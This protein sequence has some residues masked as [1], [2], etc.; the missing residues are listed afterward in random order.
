[1]TPASRA[2]SPP[3]RLLRDDASGGIMIIGIFMGLGALLG[4]FILGGVAGSILARDTT[5][6]AADSA[7]F[8]DAV[9]HA[10]AMNFVALCNIVM[11]AI[12]VV[13]LVLTLVD[14]ILSGVLA[15]TGLVATSNEATSCTRYAEQ[16]ELA[17]AMCG[18]AGICQFLEFIALK[19]DL[20]AF[21]VLRLIVPPLSS[22]QYWTAM[23]APYLAFDGSLETGLSYGRLTLSGSL[24]MIPGGGAP[25]PLNLVTNTMLAA[26][27]RAAHYFFKFLS[28]DPVFQD[29]RIALP[30]EPEASYSLCIRGTRFGLDGLEMF[31]QKNVF[32]G[33]DWLTQTTEPGATIFTMLGH[34]SGEYT[35]YIL[36]ADVPDPTIRPH[37]VAAREGLID[38]FHAGLNGAAFG[39]ADKFYLQQNTFWRRSQPGSTQLEGPKTISYYAYNGSDWSQNWTL[40]IDPVGE[41]LNLD[42][43]M[44][45]EGE[46]YFDCTSNWRS[47][48]CDKAGGSLYRM[49][50]RARLRRVHTIS[51]LDDM[52]EMYFDDAVVRQANYERVDSKLPQWLSRPVREGIIKALR[53][54]LTKLVIHQDLPADVKTIADRLPHELYH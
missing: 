36:C 33:A 4:I 24:T 37:N 9:V 2:P 13:Y 28:S 11:M 35:H 17:I 40:A 29:K 1:M 53:T 16:P 22:A 26:G 21:T 18:A 47:L 50:W 25:P 42:S 6:E 41:L 19:A 52:F 15:V 31:L 43:P 49:N 30:A 44:L 14:M 20:G 23:I 54:D 38:L 39:V 51:L 27:N 48:P 45:A 3:P 5:Q 8:A 12:T 7:A 10:R 46:Y 32:P 34:T